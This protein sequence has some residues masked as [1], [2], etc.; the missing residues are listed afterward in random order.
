M[1]LTGQSSQVPEKNHQGIPID[2]VEEPDPFA[3]QILKL[4][5]VQRD[6]IHLIKQ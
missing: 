3:A 1:R 4:Q 6:S 2:A 5:P